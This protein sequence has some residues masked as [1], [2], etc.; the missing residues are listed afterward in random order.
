[1]NGRWNILSVSENQD[2]EE[3]AEPDERLTIT[4]YQEAEPPTPE[5]D[6]DHS[7]VQG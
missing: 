6:P 2:Q 4:G 7:R 5:K 1:M 3:D